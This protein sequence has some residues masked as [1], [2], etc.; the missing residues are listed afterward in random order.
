M[1]TTQKPPAVTR[2]A[3][4]LNTG[5]FFH[6]ETLILIHRP[7]DDANCTSLPHSHKNRYSEIQKYISF[8]IVCFERDVG[9]L[10]SK[11]TDPTQ[12]KTA[13]ASKY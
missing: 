13:L 10:T 8:K 11:T 5:W 7:Q 1:K 2:Y 4:F 6:L 12:G 9:Q 3:A